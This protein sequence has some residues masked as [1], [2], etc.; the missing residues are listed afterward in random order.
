MGAGLGL[1]FAPLG[2]PFGFG[3][4]ASGPPDR[5]SRHQRSNGAGPAILYFFM[6]SAFVS[7]CSTWSRTAASFVS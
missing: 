6:T 7:P 2:L 4:S 1:D 5:Y 3:R